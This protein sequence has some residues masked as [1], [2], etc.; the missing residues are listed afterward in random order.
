[1]VEITLREWQREAISKSLNWLLHEN[2]DHRFLVGDAA[3][4]SV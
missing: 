4:N 3:P 2:G 1:M